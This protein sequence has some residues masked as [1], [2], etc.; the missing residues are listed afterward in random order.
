MRRPRLTYVVTHPVTADRFLR[1][2]LGFMREQGFDVS[3][4]G[5]PGALL[6]R[7]AERE[8]VTTVAVPMARGTDP[9]G[10]VV[11]LGQLVNALKKLRPDIVNAGTPKAGLLGMIASRLASVPVRVYLL[12][13]LRLET[14]TG[15]MRAVLGVTEHIAAACA[16]EVACVSPSL[17]RRAVDGRHIPRSKALVVGD[18]SSNGVDTEHFGWT[19]E[20]RAEG[21]RRLAEHGIRPDD[22]VIGFVGRMVADKGVSE[23][24]DAFRRVRQEFPDAKLVFVGSDLGDEQIDPE[25]VRQVKQTLNVVPTGHV[26]DVAPLY[27]RMDVLAFPSYREGFPNTLLEAACAQ[28]PVVA[29]R[30][31]GIVDAVVDAETGTLVNQ[32]DREALA[33]GILAYLR[34]PALGSAHGR[35]ARDRAARRFSRRVVWNAWLEHYRSL[36][37]RRGLPLP[38]ADGGRSNHS[39]LAHL[40]SRPAS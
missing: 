26:A 18:G 24:L 12:R 10:D 7:V 11:A 15:P 37:T 13:G 31:T 21:Q 17:L 36:L 30:S 2:Q 9:R 28:T 40:E 6:D 4:V 29:F 39:D 23:V 20:L 32:G 34:S 19:E 38:V 25:L 27:A 14:V 8:G 5:S 35:A 33:Q 3:V 22:R 1:G 16:H